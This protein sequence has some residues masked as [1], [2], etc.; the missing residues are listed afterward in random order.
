MNSHIKEIII[1]ASIVLLVIVAIIFA[2][3]IFI[4]KGENSIKKVFT[5]SQNTSTEDTIVAGTEIA[6]IINELKELKSSIVGTSLIFNS[7]V[8]GSLKDFSVVVPEEA[9]GRENPFVPTSWKLKAIAEERAR[10][11]INR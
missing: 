4:E 8:F 5:G 3:F 10:T 6:G 11:Q 7:P 9:I 2:Y 1:N